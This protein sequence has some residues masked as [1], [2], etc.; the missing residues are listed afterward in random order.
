MLAK[1][2][3]TAWLAGRIWENRQ[4]KTALLSINVTT[5]K[6]K[7]E[8]RLPSGGDNSYPGLVQF[9]NTLY[10]SYYSSHEDNKS[11]I[12]LAQFDISED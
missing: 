8:A 9:K 11:Q 12:Y 4:F 3:D 1:N 7:I 10:M 5:Q 2:N 6:L